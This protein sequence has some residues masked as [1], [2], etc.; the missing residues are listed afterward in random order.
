MQMNQFTR[1]KTLKRAVVSGS[2]TLAVG[3]ALF[4][5]SCQPNVVREVEYTKGV[6]TEVE[7]VSP[8]QFKITDE[9]VVTEKDSSKVIAHYL[10][11]EVDTMSIEEVK[12]IEESDQRRRGLSPI[13]YGGFI[14][15]YMGR[16][17]RVAPS[18]S[19]YKDQSTYNRVNST[20][21]STLNKTASRSRVRSTR[22]SGSS[23]GYGKSR[24]TRSYG[25]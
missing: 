11:G 9:Q 19:V 4:L 21:G 3:G 6:I 18:P 10:D 23:S 14:G 25:G 1:I 5:Q 2:I 13:L 15:Y 24:S 16:S 12:V 20:T 22:P 17:S 7:E 8:N